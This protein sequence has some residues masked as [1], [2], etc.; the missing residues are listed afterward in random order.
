MPPH[1]S[2]QLPRKL[3]RLSFTDTEQSLAFVTRNLLEAC[4]SLIHRR[5]RREEITNSPAPEG[6][7]NHHRRDI[8]RLR[9]GR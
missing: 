5:V 7:G 2:I 3:T 4:D 1:S 6:I 9:G 8:L